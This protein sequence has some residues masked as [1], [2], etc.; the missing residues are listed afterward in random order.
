VVLDA[1]GR[2]TAEM[3]KAGFYLFG[4]RQNNFPARPPIVRLRDAK[5]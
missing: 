4:K 3:K 5:D 1:R 2:N